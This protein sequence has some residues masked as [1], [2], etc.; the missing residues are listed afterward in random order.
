MR[1]VKAANI[2]NKDHWVETHL[3]D[4]DTTDEEEISFE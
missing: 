1:Y 2:D 3:P 4:L